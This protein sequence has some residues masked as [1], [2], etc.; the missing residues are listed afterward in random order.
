MQLPLRG[1]TIC[2]RRRTVLWLAP[3]PTTPPAGDSL[4]VSQPAPTCRGF[5]PTRELSNNHHNP[6][7]HHECKS[8]PTFTAFGAGQARHRD[9]SA[10]EHTA[11][12]YKA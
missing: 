5:L 2:W 3:R 9:A 10:T 6:A 1:A 11:K 7:P 8:T 4:L 12:R